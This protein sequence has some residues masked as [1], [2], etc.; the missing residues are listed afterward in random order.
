MNHRIL[1]RQGWSKN[2]SVTVLTSMPMGL[3]NL[4]MMGRRE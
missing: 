3:A 4:W 2:E 1:L